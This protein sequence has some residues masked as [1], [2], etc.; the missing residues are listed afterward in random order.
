LNRT[1][2]IVALGG[3]FACSE[4]EHGP[5]A[6]IALAQDEDAAPRNAADTTPRDAADTTARD[7]EASTDRNGAT[8]ASPSPGCVLP[9][10]WDVLVRCAPP[11]AP[12]TT[13]S[14]DWVRRSGFPQA[15]AEGSTQTACGQSTRWVR[16]TSTASTSWM[17]ETRYY[18]E[19]LCLTHRIVHAGPGAVEEWLDETGVV[20]AEGTAPL[21][22]A[23]S[24]RCVDGRVPGIEG[25]PDDCT[26]SP[27]VLAPLLE[28][29]SMG[30]CAD[31][32]P[33]TYEIR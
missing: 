33:D 24:V 13:Q 6:D 1:L 18:A 5:D 10:V 29:C 25:S 31:P 23:P 3:A 28:S 32:E 12:C 16:E 7:A 9:C 20:I 14:W 8:D 27:G 17:D 11:S 4:V 26:G 30:T 21:M 19:S 15:S 22:Q 2:A